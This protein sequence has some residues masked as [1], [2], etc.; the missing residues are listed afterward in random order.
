MATKKLIFRAL[1][2]VGIFLFFISAVESK[3]GESMPNNPFGAL[4]FL[5]WDHDWNSYKYPSEEELEKAVFLMKEAGVSIVRMDFL[6]RDIEPEEGVFDFSKYDTIVEV[7]TRNNLQI[8][9]L[10]NYCV[11]WAS[12]CGQWNYPSGDNC[13]FVNYACKTIEHYKGKIKYWEVWNEPDSSTYWQPQD[14]L[15]GYCSLLKEVYLAAKEVDPECI[16]LNGGL[17]NGLASVNKLYDNGAKDYFD[18]LNIHF[19]ENPLNPNTIK[20][21]A[22]YPRLA[23]KVMSRN[24]DSHKKIWITEIGCPGVKPGTDTKKWWMGKN[25]TEKQ[26]AKWLTDVYTVLLKD[27]NVEKIFWAFFRDCHEHWGTGVDYFGIVRWD[28]SKKPAY[29]SY[30]KCFKEWGKSASHK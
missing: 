19:F 20:A 4:E 10:L 30:L 27:K 8:L 26:Q 18:I 12:P 21:V 14:G 17:A 7:V 9:G 15:K 28:F 3:E 11:E 29:T 25:P 6:W 16:I 13:A 1:C 2:L 22:A 5:S 24:G 23:Y